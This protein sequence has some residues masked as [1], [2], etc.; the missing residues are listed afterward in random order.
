MKLFNVLLTEGAAASW[1]VCWSPD[2]KVRCSSPGQ[3]H[4]VVFLGKTLYSHSA[5]LYPGV[6]MGTSE[7]NAGGGGGNPAMDTSIPH[8]SRGGGLAILPSC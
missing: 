1:L 7:F 5:S 8:P 6:S 4:G 3:R 2:R